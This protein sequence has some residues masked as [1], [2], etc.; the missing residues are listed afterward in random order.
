MILSYGDV[1]CDARYSKACGGRTEEFGT[2]WDGIDV[3]YLTSVSDSAE[4]HPPIETEEQAR[5]FI[6]SSPE[7]YCHIADPAQIE[8]VLPGFDQETKGFFRWTVEYSGKELSRIIHEK[9]G[10]DLGAIREIHPLLRGPSGRI[11]RL[12]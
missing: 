3:P 6:L 10:L 5:D 7:A 1:I 2:A 12:E 9:S 4:A 8:Q 11:S